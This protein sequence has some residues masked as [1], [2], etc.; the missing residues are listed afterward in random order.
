MANF[1]K[2]ICIVLCMIFGV[3][4]AACFPQNAEP[5]ASV[6]EDASIQINPLPET[7]SKDKSTARLY[8]GYMQEPLL[9]GE[10]RIFS[11]P[12]N[13][14]ADAA[15]IKELIK[16]PSTTRADF[17]P[18][19]NAETKVTNVRSEG[20]YLFVT[21]SKEFLQPPEDQLTEENDLY[22]KTRKMLA[23]YSIVNALIEQGNYSRVQIL[24]DEEGTGNGRP[25]TLAEAG[26]EGEGTI[27]ALERKGELDLN[28]PNTLREIMKCIENK[29]WDMLYSYISYKNL[30]GEDKPSV[31]D[32]K[33]E[34]T[35]AKPVVSDYTVG[36][37]IL[38]ADSISEVVMASYTL[39]LRD[40]D[41]KTISNV[42]LRLIL[43]NDVWKMT[44][45][46]FKRNFLS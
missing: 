5:T 1:K 46:T 37:E 12:I 16:G 8:F 43:E 42:P 2:I 6:S 4:V 20:T 36:D 27:D 13:E 45:T 39:K 18:L 3:G 33:N 11:V 23:V 28:G 25:L 31:E 19:I 38:S 24:I 44:Y 14:N 17:M 21:L 32:F 34:I 15:I 22:E 41:A 26:M 7:V 30:Y 35:A 40:G 10:T 9:V 29:S